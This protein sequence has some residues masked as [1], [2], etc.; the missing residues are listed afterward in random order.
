MYLQAHIPASVSIIFYYLAIMQFIKHL[1]TSRKHNALVKYFPLCGN[2]IKYISNLK[3][4]LHS[5][6]IRG[7]KHIFKFPFLIACTIW[8]QDK[9]LKFLPLRGNKI[10]WWNIKQQRKSGVNKRCWCN[11]YF[12]LHGNKIKYINK[13]R[14]LLHFFHFVETKTLYN[15][16]VSGSNINH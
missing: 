15:F 16:I 12:A 11:S 13:N 10:H 3:V 8:V 7:N 1:S 9:S 14:K 4:L 2:E 5:L 6:P